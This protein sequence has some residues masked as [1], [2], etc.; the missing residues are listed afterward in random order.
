MGS[1]CLPSYVNASVNPAPT[2]ETPRLSPREW[3][4]SNKSRETGNNRLHGGVHTLLRCEKLVKRHHICEKSK[5]F[6][7]KKIL[8]QSQPLFVNG[9]LNVVLKFLSMQKD[10][11]RNRNANAGMA[12]KAGKLYHGCLHDIYHLDVTSTAGESISNRN[13]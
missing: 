11:Q 6:V 9:N 3:G 13:R 5:T 10:T 2:C 8:Q 12:R 7:E 1:E 4:G